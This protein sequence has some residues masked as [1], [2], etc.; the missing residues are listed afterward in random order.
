VETSG[1][2]EARTSI[3]DGH[4]AWTFFPES[5]E[6]E[7]RPAGQQRP[8]V[9][10][11]GLL[12][13]TPGSKRIAGSERLGDVTYTVLTITRPNQTRTL[14]I[15]PETKFI[16]KDQITSVSPTTRAVVGFVT[17]KFSAA[18]ALTNVDEKLFRFDPEKTHARQRAEARREALIDSV[19][20]PAPDFSL[21]D[22]QG[23][24][25]KLGELRGKA[26]LLNFW[27]TW[28]VP[29]RSE[30]PTIELLHREF[31]DKGLVVLGVDDEE[32]QTQIAFLQESGFSFA[33]LVEP[34]KQATNLYGVGGIPTTVVIDQQGTIKSYDQGTASYESLRKTLKEMGIH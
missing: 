11:Y 22:L 19:G 18:Q 23:S 7:T 21:V 13:E 1:R 29:C 8:V 12:D 5:N 2:G 20:K 31:G 16:H 30:M 34:R 33:S 15:D 32:A 28:C 25:V 27:A 6:Y 24:E 3:S 14:W 26:V 9:G 17:T 4:T 10:S